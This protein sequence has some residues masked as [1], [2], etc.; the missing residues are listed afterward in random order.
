MSRFTRRLRRLAGPLAATTLL[1]A[2]IGLGVELGEPVAVTT[3]PQV[4][5]MGVADATAPLTRPP[6]TPCTV[7]LYES[8]PFIDWREHPFSYTPD[9]ACAGPWAKVVLEADFDVT[10]G[11]QFDRTALISIGGANL[12]FG[13]T[14]EPAGLVAPRWRVERDVTEYANLFN[15]A[16]PGMVHLGTIVDD[17]YTGIITSSARLVFYPALE[18]QA[19]AATQVA[20][21]VVALSG[22]PIK[23]GPYFLSD[24]NAKLAIRVTLP[25]NVER[26]YADVIAQPQSSDEFFWSCVPDSLATILQN[27][28]GGTWREAWLTIDG[29]PAGVAPAYPWLFTG[30]IDPG[31]WRPTPGVQALNFMPYRLDLTPFAARLGDGRA[32]EIAISVPGARSG[33]SVSGNMLVYLDAGSIATSGKLLKNTLKGQVGGGEQD[34]NTIVV[35]ADGKVSGDVNMKAQRQYQIAGVLMTSRGPVTTTVQQDVA[36][37]NDQH[38]VVD[39][40]RWA[41]DVDTMTDVTQT[42][43]TTSKRG[44]TV[45][46]WVMH[47]PLTMTY[48]WDNVA[49][50][51]TLHIAHALD[52]DAQRE[53]T[54][55]GVAFESQ[56]RNRH[57]ADAKLQFNADGTVTRLSSSV[58]QHLRHTDSEGTCFDRATTAALSTLTGITNGTDCNGGN[59]INWVSLPDAAPDSGL[60]NAIVSA[61]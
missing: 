50:T 56:H 16:Q 39:A 60:M 58:S 2:C 21:R 9:A 59:Q 43:T 28:G 33:F 23:G 1:A 19:P 55:K 36:F 30:A 40:T 34:S 7:S 41:Q 25:R 46:R 24:G 35:D 47:Y 61:W 42:T 38:Y 26:I 44:Q 49:S 8:E 48:N 18:P 10:M 45:D 3:S 32:H 15:Q 11:R 31:A 4:G 17:T 6:V 57:E 12:Y 5:A 29:E 51:Q 52:R 22:D 27:C 13:T 20:D 53:V 54:R 37:R 14:Q